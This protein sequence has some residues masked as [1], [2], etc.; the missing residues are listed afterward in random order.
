MIELENIMAY[1]YRDTLPSKTVLLLPF[2]SQTTTWRRVFGFCESRSNRNNHFSYKKHWA[3]PRGSTSWYN[4]VPEECH[5]K[6]NELPRLLL[7]QQLDV[8][9]G[10]LSRKTTIRCSIL[11]H[12]FPCLFLQKLWGHHKQKGRKYF[13][14]SAETCIMVTNSSEHLNLIRN[15]KHFKFTTHIVKIQAK[16]HTKMQRRI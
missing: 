10:L 13:D 14:F 5:L 3:I 9:T 8:P 2:K 1:K 15:S 11:S 4:K 7:Q 12:L 6:K 16:S